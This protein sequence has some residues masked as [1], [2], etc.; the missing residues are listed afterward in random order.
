MHTGWQHYWCASN[1][2]ADWTTNMNMPNWDAWGEGSAR[3]GGVAPASEAAP[4]LLEA[5]PLARR[6]LWHGESSTEPMMAAVRAGSDGMCHCEDGRFN[7]LRDAQLLLPRACAAL[8]LATVAT[9]FAIM[10]AWESY[11]TTLPGIALEI[12]LVA[13]ALPAWLVWLGTLL[14]H[15][16]IQGDPSAPLVAPRVSLE[17]GADDRCA[18]LNP[19]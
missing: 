13:C 18:H 3:I 15:R 11:D 17:L 9:I 2:L 12:P 19:A 10:R 4:E 1:A 16:Q 14:A 5:R 8:L 7:R 6:R